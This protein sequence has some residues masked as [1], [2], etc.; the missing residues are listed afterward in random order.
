LLHNFDSLLLFTLVSSTGGH[1]HARY[2]LDDRASSLLEFALLVAACS[3][4]N[5]HLLTHGLNLEVVGQGVV[6]GLDA[7]I[8]PP[9]KEFGLHGELGFVVLFGNKRVVAVS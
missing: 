4:W 3:V 1:E 9:S 2:A 5:E 7:L 6:G 8:R